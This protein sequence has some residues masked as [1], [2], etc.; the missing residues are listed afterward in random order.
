MQGLPDHKSDF[1]R[2]RK[3]QMLIKELRFAELTYGA[4]VEFVTIQYRSIVPTV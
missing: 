3:G 1:T 4:Y 2:K